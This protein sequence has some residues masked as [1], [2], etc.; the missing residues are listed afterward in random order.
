[1]AKRII[2]SL[3]ALLLGGILILRAQPL[4]LAAPDFQRSTP[5]PVAEEEAAAEEEVPAPEPTLQDLLARIEALEAQVAALRVQTSPT[6]QINQ[7]TTAVYLLDNAGLHDLDVRLNEEGLI[8]PYESGAVAR[9]A[10]LLSTVEWPHEMAADAETLIDILADLSAALADDDLETAAPLAVDAHDLGHDLSHVAEHWLGEGSA[11]HSAHD[12]P[13]Q[14]FRVT[15]AVYLLDNA[16]LHDL[17][18]RLNEEGLIQ[19][20]D[21]GSVARIARLLSTVD[22]PVDMTAD[23][24]TLIGILSDLSAALADDDL[25]TAAPLATDAHD[26]GHDLSHAAEHWLSTRSG[27]HGDHNDDAAHEDNHGHNHEDDDHS[28]TEDSEG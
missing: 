7:V 24:E 17:D 22:W 11:V 5:T 4:T 15:A 27:A 16:G 21:S 3:C 19:P 13:G 20:Y 2:F 12:A 14:I 18:V 28:H 10:R 25:D 23:A 6:A 1:M 8:Q 9:I 26:L